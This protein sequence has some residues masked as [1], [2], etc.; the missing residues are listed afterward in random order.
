MTARPPHDAAAVPP[1]LTAFLR[2]VERRGAVF[3]HLLAG[4][5]ASGD[6]ALAATMEVFRAEA[7][8]T[9]FGDWPRRFWSQL[10]A[11]PTLR[12]PPAEPTWEPGFEWLA[13][14][15]HGP[16][17]A[18]LLRLVAGLAESD[19][20]A[21]LGIARGTYRLGLQRALP[22]NADGSADLAAWQA[23]GA[24]A[25]GML[26]GLPPDRLAH[27][28]HVREEAIAAPAAGA[29][30][31]V[32][33]EVPAG[34]RHRA[35]LWGIALLTLLAF[36]ATF[37]PGFGGGG[38]AG[39]DGPEG[40]QVEALPAAAAPAARYPD[41]DA[42][43]LHPDLRLLLDAGSAG[44]EAIDPAFHAWFAAQHAAANAADGSPGAPARTVGGVQGQMVEPDLHSETDDA[45]L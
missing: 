2:G 40:I 31:R 3:A 29:R 44:P 5:Q 15:G 7:G 25:Q 14:L 26:R 32:E 8:R 18:L 37:W 35:A 34:P 10:L 22:H 36:A 4:S 16:R 39:G 45:S 41:A 20:A 1:A 28:A 23:L 17:A 38:F 24:A 33:L 6:A 27:L 30:R 9:A 11:Q 13:E 12:Q 43:A 21:V 19:A 42:L